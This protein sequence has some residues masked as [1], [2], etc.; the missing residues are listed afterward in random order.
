V[1]D[2]GGLP[3]APAVISGQRGRYGGSAGRVGGHLAGMRRG[4]TGREDHVIG[5]CLVKE[6]LRIGLGSNG[7]EVVDLDAEIGCG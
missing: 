6:G 3:P 7:F 1:R 4:F 5:L 2:L